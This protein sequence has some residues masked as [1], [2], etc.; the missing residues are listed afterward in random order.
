MDEG[1]RYPGSLVVQHVKQ[2]TLE[3][4]DKYRRRRKRATELPRAASL[5]LAWEGAIVAGAFLVAI[6]HVAA[7]AYMME[8]FDE[9]TRRTSLVRYYQQRAE[10]AAEAVRHVQDSI[11]YYSRHAAAV[12]RQLECSNAAAR[13]CR[14][15]LLERR[16]QLEKELAAALGREARPSGSGG[17]GGALAS[18]LAPWRAIYVRL[19]LDGWRR[20]LE[21]MDREAGH[22]EQSLQHYHRLAEQA[23]NKSCGAR[24]PPTRRSMRV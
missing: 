16:R 24:L 5:L 10:L 1:P 23:R 19:R 22:L 12:E 11:A 18:V 2:Q 4:V 8:R 3:L 7:S 14:Q 20:E 15:R 17:G 9:R 6:A 21:G 13:E